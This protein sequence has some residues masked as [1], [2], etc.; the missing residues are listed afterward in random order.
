MLRQLRKLRRDRKRDRFDETHDA[1]SA[2][3]EVVEAADRLGLRSRE[4]DR[5]AEEALECA[6]RKQIDSMGVKHRRGPPPLSE[7]SSGPQEIDPP[8]RRRQLPRGDAA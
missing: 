3:T 7:P 2:V 6:L 5:A 4:I 1:V 8:E